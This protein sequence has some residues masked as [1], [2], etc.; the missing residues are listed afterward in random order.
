[1]AVKKTVAIGKLDT[2]AYLKLKGQLFYLPLILLSTG[3]NV[4]T[5]DKAASTC[6]CYENNFDTMDILKRFWEPRGPIGH[7]LKS[8]YCRII[9]NWGLNDIPE[10]SQHPQMFAKSSEFKLAGVYWEYILY[11]VSINYS[12]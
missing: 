10:A 12:E 1:M 6:Q 2:T 7:F 3:A 4:D 9:E 11:N 8:H 5:V